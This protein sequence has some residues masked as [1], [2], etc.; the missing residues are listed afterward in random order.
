MIVWSEETVITNSYEEENALI[1]RALRYAEKNGIYLAI[2]YDNQIND[3]L[4]ENKMVVLSP[5]FEVKIDYQ[6]AHPVPILVC[7]IMI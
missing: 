7:I 5:N 2:T 6:K 1:N 3:N 4:A